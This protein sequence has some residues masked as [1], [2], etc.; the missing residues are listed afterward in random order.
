MRKIP[1]VTATT[2][3]GVVTMVQ[4]NSLDLWDLDDDAPWHMSSALASSNS[5]PTIGVVVRI[6]IEDGR[7]ASIDLSSEASL[8]RRQMQTLR[9]VIDLDE[10]GEARVHE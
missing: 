8:T 10:L 5:K 2:H 9:S 7:P 1:A 4:G 6:L 3:H